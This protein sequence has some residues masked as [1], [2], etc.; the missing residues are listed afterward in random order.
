MG[1]LDFLTGNTV[2]NAFYKNG[3]KNVANEKD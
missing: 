3:F 1:K 2:T